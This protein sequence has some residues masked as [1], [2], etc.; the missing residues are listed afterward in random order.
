MASRK[1]A[2]PNAKAP[3]AAPA[4]DSSNFRARRLSLNDL[5]TT[6][7]DRK[8]GGTP[9]ASHRGRQ[10]RLSMRYARPCVASHPCNQAHLLFVPPRS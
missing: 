8:S 3:A 5:D 6:E 7:F 1:Q 9:E 2:S 4:R 10:R